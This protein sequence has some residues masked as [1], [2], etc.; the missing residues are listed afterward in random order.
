[1]GRAGKKANL[2][3]DCDVVVAA[4]SRIALKG[5]QDWQED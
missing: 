5:S 4:D 2:V 1:M 3:M